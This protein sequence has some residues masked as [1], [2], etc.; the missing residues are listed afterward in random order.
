[1]PK[2]K[3]AFQVTDKTE[4]FLIEKNLSMNISQI[5]NFLPK[6]SKLSDNEEVD[7]IKNYLCGDIRFKFEERNSTLSLTTHKEK[8]DLLSNTFVIMDL[9]TTGLDYTKSNIT[10]IGAIKI[11]DGKEIDRF[12][13]LI[14]PEMVI[15][16]NIIELTGIDNEMVK[17]SEN[18]KNVVDGFL[19]FLDDNIFVAQNASFDFFF[20]N[21][22]LEKISKK[23]IENNIICTAKFAHFLLPNLG[24]YNLDSLADHF[25]FPIGNRHRSIDDVELTIQVFLELL[26]IYK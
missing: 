7:L 17:N 9:E 4:Q 5:Q 3:P 22:H 6:D 16:P 12:H 18:F 20:L 19:K 11:K 23:R 15:P 26:K 10:E 2:Y 25:N 8:D 21:Y 24:K 14:N 13:T 1:M